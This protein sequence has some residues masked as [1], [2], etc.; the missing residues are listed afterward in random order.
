MK[1]NAPIRASGLQLDSP[2]IDDE[3]AV[4]VMVNR[5]RVFLRSIDP[6][7]DHFKNK[8]VVLI[9]QPC[10]DDIALQIGEALGDKW[11][12]NLLGRSCCQAEAL[13]FVYVLARAV[14]NAND[15]A[16]QFPRRNGNDTLF[17]GA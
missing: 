10:I 12:R 1:R 15:L 16:R 4:T 13:E 14:A 11:R 2:S 7:F 8:Q 6:G 5:L 17:G 9:R 3:L